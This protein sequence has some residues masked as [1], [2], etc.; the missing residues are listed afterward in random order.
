MRIASLTSVPRRFSVDQPLSLNLSHHDSISS[1]LTHHNLTPLS[2]P[3]LSPRLPALPLPLPLASE[4]V[5]LAN[6][7]SFRD[8]THAV[9]PT[10]QRADAELEG[11]YR[12]FYNDAALEKL[13]N[14]T[15]IL[16]SGSEIELSY[17]KINVCQG[18][19]VQHTILVLVEMA[20]DSK[21]LIVGSVRCPCDI[22]TLASRY[23]LEKTRR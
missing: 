20:V 5:G 22:N 1:L 21:F 12:L 14:L 19:V 3:L 7:Y 8:A 6:I 13:P 10:E 2:T 23:E 15:I 16:G 9:V 4:D 17:S 11:N 18:I